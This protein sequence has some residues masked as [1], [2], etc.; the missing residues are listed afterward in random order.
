MSTLPHIQDIQLGDLNPSSFSGFYLKNFNKQRK[1]KNEKKIPKNPAS[2]H[3]RLDDK[4]ER[5]DWCPV[6]KEVVG[7]R[8]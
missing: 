4:N 7:E 3:H 6:L 5:Q 8:F 2:V 1:Q